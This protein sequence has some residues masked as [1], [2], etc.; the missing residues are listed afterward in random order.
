MLI[1]L[2]AGS[3]ALGTGCIKQPQMANQM[4]QPFQQILDQQR[5]EY[6][7]PGLSAAVILPDSTIWVGSSGHSSDSEAVDASMLFGLGSVTKTYIAALVLQLE[8]EGALSADQAIGQWIPGLSQIDDNIT[9]KQL[10]N[11]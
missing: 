4:I 5:Q 10:L 1:A 8:E 2:F 6:S 9:I 11:H 3:V 7:V